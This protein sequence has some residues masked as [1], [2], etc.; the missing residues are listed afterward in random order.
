M[1]KLT[2]F[3]RRYS[4]TPELILKNLA[5]KPSSDVTFEASIDSSCF[6]TNVKET[7]EISNFASGDNLS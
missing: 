7:G 6:F 3:V 5:L 4:I 2:I 1:L